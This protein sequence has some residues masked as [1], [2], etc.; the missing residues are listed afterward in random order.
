MDSIEPFSLD[1]LTEY[2]HAYLSGFLAEKYDVSVEDAKERATSRAIQTAIDVCKESVIHQTKT[3]ANNNLV[4]KDNKNDY[5]LLP[6]WMVNIN[7]NNK[8]YTFA[9][10]GQTGKLVGNIPLDIKKTVII[11]II[12]FVVITLIS[13]GI[14]WKV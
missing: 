13:F 4:T 8:K 14:I 6:V 7:Y 3:V 11:S 12:L 2:N 10:N 5:I 1:E 9:M